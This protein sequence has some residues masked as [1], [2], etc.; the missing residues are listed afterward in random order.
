MLLHHP[1]PRG[2]LSNRWWRWHGRASAIKSRVVL[3]YH[4]PQMV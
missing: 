2:F 4:P 3:P 1:P